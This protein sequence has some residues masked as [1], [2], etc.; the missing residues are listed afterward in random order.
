M[1]YELYEGLR[2]SKETK[3]AEVMSQLL[4]KIQKQADSLIQGQP[5]TQ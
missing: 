5:K 1:K 2:E 3:V 4:S